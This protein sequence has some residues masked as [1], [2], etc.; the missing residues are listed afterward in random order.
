MSAEARAKLAASRRARWT[1]IKAAGAGT[2][3]ARK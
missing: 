3:E 1:K 2:E